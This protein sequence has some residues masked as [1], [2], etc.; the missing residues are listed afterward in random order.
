[1]ASAVVVMVVVVVVVAVAVIKCTNSVVLSLHYLQHFQLSSIQRTRLP[2]Q[3]ECRRSFVESRKPLEE[4]V[5][6]DGV[7]HGYR[8]IRNHCLYARDGY[9]FFR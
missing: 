2:W 9:C 4:P 5:A 6:D 1:M 8:D 3:H 7:Q